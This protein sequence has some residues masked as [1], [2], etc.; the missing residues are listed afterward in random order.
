MPRYRI[1]EDDG[2]VHEIDGPEGASRQQVIAAIQADIANEN[3]N[4]AEEDY[5]QYLA[6]R[7]RS[8]G[9]RAKTPRRYYRCR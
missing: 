1:T 6:T 9:S 8:G 3:V 7:G 2:T 5:E 4:K